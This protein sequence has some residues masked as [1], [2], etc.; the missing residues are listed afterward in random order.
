MPSYSI[1]I[2]YFK[3]GW[4]IERGFDW[5]HEPPLDLPLNIWAMAWD[6]QQC[7]MCDQQS[8]RSACAYAQSDQ[9]ICQSLEYSMTVKLLPEHHLEFLSLTGGCT[10]SSESTYVKIPHCWKSHV[11]A[12]LSRFSKTRVTYLFWLVYN[13][14]MT[15]G[16]ALNIF[17]CIRKLHCAWCVSSVSD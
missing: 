14:F 11:M 10:C 12:Q 16:F 9:S 5:T 3:T 4:G 1:L 15:W 2:G 8:L 13:C 17:N 6:F 7:G